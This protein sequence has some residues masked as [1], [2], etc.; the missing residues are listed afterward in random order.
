MRPLPIPELCPHPPPSSPPQVG[1]PLRPPAALV[2]HERPGVCAVAW[3][4]QDPSRVATASD[5]ISVKLWELQLGDLRPA[6]S[7]PEQP[8]AGTP[9][10]SSSQLTPLEDTLMSRQN[11]AT[12]AVD[13]ETS[14]PLAPYPLATLAAETPAPLSGMAS[15]LRHER[16]CGLVPSRAPSFSLAPFPS[17]A[18]ALPSPVHLTGAAGPSLSPAPLHHAALAPDG[19]SPRSRTEAETA[20]LEHLGDGGREI[21][22]APGDLSHPPPPLLTTSSSNSSKQLHPSALPSSPS[23]MVRPGALL[24]K[25]VRSAI[26]PLMSRLRGASGSQG[27]PTAATPTMQ[28]KE[29]PLPSG[30]AQSPVL[31]LAF[32]LAGC[33]AIPSPEVRAHTAAPTDP[34]HQPSC[35]IPQDGKR[36]TGHVAVSGS[37]P[38]PDADGPL[39]EAPFDEDDDKE[40]IDPAKAA[41]LAAMA[42]TLPPS[43]PM[44]ENRASVV[45]DGYLSTSP[46]PPPAEEPAAVAARVVPSDDPA[47][48]ALVTLVAP[49]GFGGAQGPNTALGSAS[50]KR[51]WQPP[52]DGAASCEVS[53]ER[54]AKRRELD[55]AQEE[56]EATAGPSPAPAKVASYSWGRDSQVPC[57]DPFDE[58]SRPLSGC[59]NSPLLTDALAC[60]RKVEG[61]ALLGVTMDKQALEAWAKRQSKMNEAAASGRGVVGD[62]MGGGD[63]VAG[64]PSG[65]QLQCQQQLMAHLDAASRCAWEPG[66]M[67]SATYSDSEDGAHDSDSEDDYDDYSDDDDNDAD[68]DRLGGGDADEDLGPGIF[69][70]R[71]YP[72]A[73]PPP[74]REPPPA[75]TPLPL[76]A[77][78]DRAQ[79]PKGPKPPR[80][81]KPRGTKRK[82][83]PVSARKPPDHATDAALRASKVKQ[84][85]LFELWGGKGKEEGKHA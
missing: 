35:I 67:P 74:V 82:L 52:P 72:P 38:P 37:P 6:L 5:D 68:G 29:A 44:L 43:S 63:S 27:A 70:L 73:G 60:Q 39:C 41:G 50:S 32:D 84:R 81:T 1:R 7:P 51:P 46:P 33:A 69:L 77:R 18:G 49:L 17:S 71:G 64:G 57:L 11:A 8:T 2:G 48:I 83:A 12:V 9:L 16:E 58:D 36:D 55:V 22:L 56:T 21:S 13:G 24:P 75:A 45:G 14:T 54:E 25:P 4:H 79:R 26:S 23:L 62:S 28:Q 31:R 47:A 76:A 61:E 66:M 59:A 19:A 3:S 65:L 40:N 20:Q 53:E 80:A 85:T 34:P 10:V 78:G 15:F 30:F 42:P